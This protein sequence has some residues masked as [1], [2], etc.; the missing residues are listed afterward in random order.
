MHGVFS[1]CRVWL[2]WWPHLEA[3]ELYYFFLL[4]LSS[5]RCFIVATSEVKQTVV[6]HLARNERVE[7]PRRL[8]ARAPASAA[9]ANANTE[10]PAREASCTGRCLCAMHTT[11]HLLEVDDRL[12]FGRPSYRQLFVVLRQR[13]WLRSATN[14]S[15]RCKATLSLDGIDNPLL[16]WEQRCSVMGQLGS[17]CHVRK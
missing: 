3:A 17:G 9:G 14:K 5:R 4:L 12:P 13:P 15:C 7:C 11:P 8:A 10:R 6:S 16:S 1:P 2:G